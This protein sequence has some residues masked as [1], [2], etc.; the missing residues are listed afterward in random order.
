MRAIAESDPKANTEN[1][2]IKS[3]M[4]RGDM[5]QNES[6]AKIME[7][8]LNNLRDKKGIIIDGYPRDF[9]QVHDFEKKVCENT[10]SNAIEHT[11][12]YI[13]QS[14]ILLAVPSTTT[15]Y[16]IGLLEA[17]VGTRPVR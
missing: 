11:R 12:C 6:I 8:H 7:T 3:S 13:D 14:F 9:D 2:K 15:S 17:A 16:P 10:L 5:I 4:S 1:H